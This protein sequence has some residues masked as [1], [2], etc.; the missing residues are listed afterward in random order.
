MTALAPLKLVP[1]IWTLVPT[2]PL[3]GAKSLMVGGLAVT[4]KLPKLLTVPP[5]VVT[6]IGPLVAVAGTVVWIVVGEFTA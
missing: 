4:L 1:L 5:S 6:L 2:G 3:A